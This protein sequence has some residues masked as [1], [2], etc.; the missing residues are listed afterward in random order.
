M[1]LFPEVAL[2]NQYGNEN[3]DNAKPE[4]SIYF[5]PP[6]TAPSGAANRFPL[7]YGT[8]PIPRLLVYLRRFETEFLSQRSQKAGTIVS[9]IH[10]SNQFS[11]SVWKLLGLIGYKVQ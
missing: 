11:M 4:R 3:W 7:D 8:K 10:C 2:N 9:S 6:L 1:S 5:T